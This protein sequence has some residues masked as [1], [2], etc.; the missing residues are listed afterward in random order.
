MVCPASN[1]LVKLMDRVRPDQLNVVA[2][3]TSDSVVK[4]FVGHLRYLVLS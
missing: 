1:S 4:A 2:A 3:D